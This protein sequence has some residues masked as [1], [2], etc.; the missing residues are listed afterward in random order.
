V[1]DGVQQDRQAIEA[2]ISDL[3]ESMQAKL[4][5]PLSV[6]NNG[7]LR[8]QYIWRTEQEIRRLER[9]LEEAQA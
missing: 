9:L 6:V 7:P 1:T 5:N 4:D 2:E 3:R 8:N